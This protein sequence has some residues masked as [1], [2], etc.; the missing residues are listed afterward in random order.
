VRAAPRGFACYWGV[1]CGRA[2]GFANG[3]WHQVLSPRA[4]A[5]KERGC[6]SLGR[7]SH[8]F[9]ALPKY[10]GEAAAC[11]RSLSF[12]RCWRQMSCSRCRPAAM[13]KPNSLA[14]RLRAIE[15]LRKKIRTAAALSRFG[16]VAEFLINQARSLASHLLWR[17]GVG[18]RGVSP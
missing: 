2:A 10:G 14:C 13:A 6:C 18:V 16:R 12:A 4:L 17:D 11:R 8:D 7:L 9:L 15:N 3:F 5:Q 1:V